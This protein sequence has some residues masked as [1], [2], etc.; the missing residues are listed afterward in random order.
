MKHILVVDDDPAMLTLLS[1][2][3]S[4]ANYRVTTAPS[5]PVAIAATAADSLDLL[6]TDYR[7]PDMNGRELIIAL[8]A[9]RPG[10]K[11]LVVTGFPPGDGEDRAWWVRQPF[12]SKPFSVASLQNAVDALIGPSRP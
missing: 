9:D 10:L 2:V 1:R 3:L 5:G 6:V 4:A 12:L 11:T 8:Q 7:M